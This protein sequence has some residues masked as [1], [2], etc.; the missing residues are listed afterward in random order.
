MIILLDYLQLPPLLRCI[1]PGGHP[2]LL[3]VRDRRHDEALVHLVV[4]QVAPLQR[5]DPP[6]MQLL[7][8][9]GCLLGLLWSVAN[10]SV[11][12]TRIT[13]VLRCSGRTSNL[14]YE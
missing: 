1:L 11:M 14:E 7:H 9:L 13:D 3:D 12:T 4:V 5:V 8:A 6:L 2:V 10:Q